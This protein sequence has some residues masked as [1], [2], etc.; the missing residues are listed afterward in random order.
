MDKKFHIS[1][2]VGECCDYIRELAGR[3][4]GGMKTD[5][6]HCLKNNSLLL[7]E[8]E[9]KQGWAPKQQSVIAINVLDIV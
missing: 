1:K 3:G 6:L 9:E 7:R 2:K 5:F 8:R 4:G